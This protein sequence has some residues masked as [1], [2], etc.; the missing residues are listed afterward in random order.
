M[1]DPKNDPEELEI[2]DDEGEFDI[3]EEGEPIDL[4]LEDRLLED[5]GF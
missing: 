2:D 4:T 3:D 5:G 1:R